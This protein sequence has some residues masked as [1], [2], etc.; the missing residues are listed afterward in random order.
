MEE[1]RDGKVSVVERRITIA[2]NIFCISVPV[3]VSAIFDKD[4][5]ACSRTTV[6][7]DV[8]NASS[9]GNRAS[10]FSNIWKIFPNSSAIAKRT[11]SS[12]FLIKSIFWLI[13]KV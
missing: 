11:S 12:S 2:A 8:H 7:S 13:T 5:T 6:S 4:L 1:T 9:K 3:N 10:L